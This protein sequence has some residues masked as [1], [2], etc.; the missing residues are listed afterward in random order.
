M[1]APP[2]LVISCVLL[3]SQIDLYQFLAPSGIL[4]MELFCLPVEMRIHLPAFDC[5]TSPDVFLH[6]FSELPVCH[7]NDVFL[8]A[9]G[10]GYVLNFKIPLCSDLWFFYFRLLS[11]DIADHLH[12]AISLYTKTTPPGTCVPTRQPLIKIY[13]TLL[14]RQPV[15]IS[16]SH[17]PSPS[18]HQGPFRS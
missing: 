10:A 18:R 3:K 14:V 7:R 11:A 6:I 1:C 17:C 15:H 16:R 9:E 8:I 2:S 4:F 5:L 12:T 13:R